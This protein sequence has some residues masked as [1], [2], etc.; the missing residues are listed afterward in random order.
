MT[1]FFKVCALKEN[2]KKTNLIAYNKWKATHNCSVNYNG[3]APGMECAGAKRIFE[4]SQEKHGLR[5]TKLL[6]DGDSKS[7]ATVKTL[8]KG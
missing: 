8:M 1:R 5:Y 7:F 3:S 6:S 2:I 4:R